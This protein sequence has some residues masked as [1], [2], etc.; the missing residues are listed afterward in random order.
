MTRLLETLPGVAGLLTEHGSECNGMTFLE[1]TNSEIIGR[2]QFRDETVS[3][4]CKFH[5]VPY[6]VL[7]SHLVQI[8][9]RSG[10]QLRF[11]TEFSSIIVAPGQRP[12]V[13]TIR[14]E[15]IE[16]DVLIGTDGHGSIIHQALA[17]KPGGRAHRHGFPT[18]LIPNPVSREFCICKAESLPTMRGKLAGRC[19]GEIVASTSMPSNKVAVYMPYTFIY[20][21]GMYYYHGSSDQLLDV[22]LLKSSTLLEW[23][24][25]D[26]C[27]TFEVIHD[28]ITSAIGSVPPAH[29][30]ELL[31][32]YRKKSEK[33]SYLVIPSDSRAAFSEA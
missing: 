9:G 6:D 29:F 21:L 15:Q 18:C 5:M 33:L 4:L 25:L 28:Q 32:S 14:G 3:D 31:T 16:A 13:T 1:G 12:A 19:L 10:V 23:M 20:G 24:Q 30:A 11:E 7:M 8:C 22:H 2:M 27:A 26:L 17:Q